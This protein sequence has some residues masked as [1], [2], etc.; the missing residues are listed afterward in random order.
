LIIGILAIDPGLL[1]SLYP[2]PLRI[3]RIRGEKTREDGKF[4]AVR[5]FASLGLYTTLGDACSDALYGGL[6]VPLIY[7]SRE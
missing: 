7:L 1:N 4:L 5:G 2:V 6:K 3:P